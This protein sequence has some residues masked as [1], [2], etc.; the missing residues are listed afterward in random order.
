MKIKF[1]LFFLLLFLLFI[2]ISKEGLSE[3]ISFDSKYPNSLTL[4]N[5]NILIVTEDGLFL[6]D[7]ILKKISIVLNI[8]SG[9]S[10]HTTFLQL[11]EDEGGNIFC[12]V[13]DILYILSSNANNVI[14]FNLPEEIIDHFC[15]LNY[16]KKDNN[17]IYYS[18]VFSDNSKKFNLL[19]YK[20]NFEAKI[21]NLIISKTYES[22]N[23]EGNTQILFYINIACEYM[24]S[25]SL[26]KVLVCFHENV[27]ASEIGISYF[28]PE[29]NLDPISSISNN[30]YI[31]LEERLSMIKSVV[32]KNLKKSLICYLYNAG[33]GA[34]CFFFNINDYSYT[35]PIKYEEYCMPSIMNFRIYF[36]KKTNKFLFVCGGLSMFFKF[37]FFN[38]NNGVQI[39]VEDINMN[40]CYSY[41]SISIS[42]L[43]NNLQYILISDATCNENGEMVQLTRF[44]SI[45]NFI[46]ITNITSIVL[47]SPSSSYIYSYSSNSNEDYNP[48]ILKDLICPENLPFFNKKLMNV[49]KIV[50]QKKY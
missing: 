4:N 23:S 50:H 12:L 30:I 31:K 29:N 14:Y 45:D 27:D 46:N 32:S 10:V 8:T 24:N 22:I 17:Y 28:S 1:K 5:G 2:A 49:L 16:Y 9:A 39:K 7:I 43:Q 34:F 44:F 19:Y 36:F 40:N 35:E 48:I 38:E 26:G 41:Y 42:F 18:L 21:N 11:P 20:M 25:D 37:I 33:N 47:D 6:Y 15:S 13:N 3:I